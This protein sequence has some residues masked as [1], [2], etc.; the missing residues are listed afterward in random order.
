MREYK[1]N[2]KVGDLI[3][4]GRFRNV[5]TKIKGIEIDEHGQPVILTSKGKK[6]LFSCRIA[7]LHPGARTP[8][9]ILM[10]KRKR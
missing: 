4:V 1:L 7:K 2:I 10:E 9:Q 5:Q 6:K 3:E 8:K